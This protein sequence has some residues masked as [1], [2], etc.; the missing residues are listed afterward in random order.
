MMNELEI[1]KTFDIFKGTNGI[2]EVRIING[3]TNYSGYFMD[4]DNLIKCLKPFEKEKNA[5]I[6]F[7]LNTINE[8][9]YSREQRER[10]VQNP[11]VTTADTD[12]I[13]RDWLLI[14]I[15]PTRS[16]GVSSSDEEKENARKIAISVFR[17]LKNMGFTAPITCDSGNGY[18]MLYKVSMANTEENKELVKNFLNALDMMF[19]DETASVDVSVFNAARITK[20]YGTVAKKGTNSTTRPHRVSRLISVPEEIESTKKVLLER[21]VDTIPKPEQPSYKNNYNTHFD[22]DE[23]IAKHNIQVDR[24]VPYGNGKKYIL[25]ECVFDATH[26]APDACIFVMNNGGIGYHCFHNSCQRYTWKDVRRKFEPESADKRN[27]FRQNTKYAKPTGTTIEELTGHSQDEETH[28]GN[29]FINFSDIE[30]KDYSK[31][32]TIPSGFTELDKKI[33]G[34]NKGEI[35]L[36]SG[37]NGSNKSGTLTQICLN[38]VNSGYKCALFSGEL[39]MQKIKNWVGLQ[40]AGRQNVRASQFYDDSYYVPDEI[41][42]KIDNWLNDKFYVYNNDFGNKFENVLKHIKELCET[43]EIDM[44]VLDNL[45]ALDILT[46]NGDKYQQ[47]TTMILALADFVKR[48]NV[49]LHIVCH[50]R[51]SVTFLRKD[52]ISG[53]ADLTNA[54]DNV[55]I[56]HRV[57]QD[58]IRSAKEFYGEP[59]A[60]QYYTCGNVIEVCK[61]RDRGVMD[62]LIG[63]YFEIPSKRML[64]APLENVVYGWEINPMDIW[65]SDLIE[66]PCDQLPF[67]DTPE[68]ENNGNL[69]Y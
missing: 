37:K 32:V 7:V 45:M 61:N 52:D 44:I 38:A 57:G 69:P 3:K 43:K 18:H 15:D 60:S 47:Q 10:F 58:F 24:I 34:F 11:K 1:R 40:A 13:G 48:Y 56:V 59:V 41:V 64:N 63:M 65:K 6:Y 67:D 66:I 8:A 20:L 33:H 53:T 51:K 23:F 2:M 28:T 26:T 30:K 55:F 25:K 54:V 22:I 39:T 14:D 19:S 68:E 17:Y 4:V 42:D 12:I 36:W 9:C 21:V 62:E 50:P 49:H 27:Y 31:I 46:L 5:N 16:T 35:S 29:P